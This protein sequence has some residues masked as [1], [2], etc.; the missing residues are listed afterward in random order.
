M[1]PGSGVGRAFFVAAFRGFFHFQACPQKPPAYG[2]WKWKT[3]ADFVKCLTSTSRL[4]NLRPGFR[5]GIQAS[6]FNPGS[7]KMET[8]CGS[9]VKNG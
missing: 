4:P 5:G 7:G 8:L 3:Y 1:V 2:V 9:P 6:N